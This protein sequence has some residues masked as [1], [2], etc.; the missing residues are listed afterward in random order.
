MEGRICFEW[1]TLGPV[2]D[3]EERTTG[4]NLYAEGKLRKQ[5][6]GGS[7]CGNGVQGRSRSPSWPRGE[8]LFFRGE[9]AREKVVEGGLRGVGR[10]PREPVS[11]SPASPGLT[12][13]G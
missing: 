5:A 3:E 8:Q 7:P 13:L 9:A 1:R 2:V 12:R 10:K 4:E 6:P 11:R